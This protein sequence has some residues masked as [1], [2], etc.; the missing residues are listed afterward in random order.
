MVDKADVSV[1]LSM[2]I[3]VQL[4]PKRLPK[5]LISRKLRN[6]HSH[7]PSLSPVVQGGPFLRRLGTTL[8]LE[9]TLI[10]DFLLLFPDVTLDHSFQEPASLQA[11]PDQPLSILLQTFGAYCDEPIEFFRDLAPF[12]VERVISS[13]TTL[14]RQKDR[15]DGL[16]LIVSGSLR[17]TYSYDDHR[18]LVQE[19]MVAGTIAGDLST[20]SDTARNA[21]V[22]AERDCILWKMDKEGLER[23][24]K[25]KPG[26]A[27]RY[28]RI[29]LKGMSL[30]TE[31]VTAC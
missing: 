10:F 1:P 31:R 22:V 15:P 20:L 25:E 23:L 8:Y 9:V 21:T 27:Q 16:Y 26:V 17:A 11:E 28:I 13:G 3:S 2:T 30:G 19:T 7:L 14:W 18:E 29:V 12:Y 4:R 24:E 5:A 6:R